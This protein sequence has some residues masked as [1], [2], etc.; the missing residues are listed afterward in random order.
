MSG[1]FEVIGSRAPRKDAPNKST[2]KARYIEDIKFPGELAGALL[3]SPQAHAKIKRI[4]ISRAQALPGVVAVITAQDVPDVKYG[5]SPAR[6]DETLFA[7]DRVRYVGD[8]IAAVAAEDLATAQRAVEFIEVEY[9]PLPVLLTVEQATAEGAPWLHEQFPD[10]VC[11]QVEQEFGDVEAAFAG[12]DLIQEGSFFSK[13][14]DGAFIEPNQCVALMD[15]D[16]VLNLHSSTQV[17]HYV[18][19]TLAMVT[20]LNMSKVRVVKPYVGGGF[21]PKASATP[22][23]LAAGF[24]AM[25]TGRPVR[26]AYTREQV[27]LFSRA[28]HGFTHHMKIG[29]KKDGT[30]MALDH[31]A[32][33]DGGAYSS[34][35]IATV[36][37]AGSLLGGP[38]KLPNMRYHGLR[39]F[40][41][42]PACGAQRGHG[43]V[44]ARALFEQQMDVIAERLG[45][46]P[47]ELRLKNMMETGDVTCNDLAMSSLG[48]RECIEAVKN[49]SGWDQKKGKLPKGKGI[50]MACGFFVSGAGYPIYRSETYHCTIM[51]KADEDGGGIVVYTASA[52][53]GQGSETTMAMIAAEAVGIPYEQVR[54]KSG[55][56]DFG[57]DLGAYSSRTTLMTGHA[58][59]EAGENLK[60]MIL[61][62]LAQELEI[63]QSRLDIKN[64]L[65][66]ISGDPVDFS[67]IRIGYIKEHRGWQDQPSGDELTFREAA[68]LAYLRRGTLV[69]TGKYKPPVLGGK[70]KGAAVGTSPA[71]GCSAQVAEVSVDFETGQIKVERITDAHD[72]GQAVNLTSVEA[73]MQ[74]S[75]SMGLGEALFE[76]VKFD[77]QGRILNPSLGEYHIPTV[78]DMPETKCIV[79][80]SGEPNGPF[81]AKEVGEGAIM[82]TIPAILNAVRNAT[83]LVLDETPLTPERVYLAIKKQKGA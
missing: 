49:G 29:V 52:E 77:G 14:Q 20:G 22:I 61:E 63:D 43:G 60:A 78:M 41:N 81:G 30:L 36:Y 75:V 79:V 54:V 48:M 59:K 44:I 64:G 19:R 46:D 13:R 50:G 10:N 37:Y 53:I 6:Y 66:K 12:C 51:I 71:Y 21:G 73:Q 16:G 27:F 40:T 39:V 65:I 15:S 4:D 70:Y 47:I 34:F 5:V 18:Q 8:E 62:T 24:L 76:E 2:G 82:P 72:C 58:T 17:P 45:M 38:Y 83:G 28:R 69:S 42:K 26:M 23:D 31:R 80:E 7:V 32:T 56:T 74:G 1:N 25:K 55:D 35:G 3:Q 57:I 11:A 68:R 67:A 33:L 9:E